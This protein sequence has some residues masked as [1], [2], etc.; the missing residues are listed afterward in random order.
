[1]FQEF[2]P[3][4][5]KILIDAEQVFQAYAHAREL[6]SSYRGSMH[7]KTVNG[8]KYLYRASNTSIPAKSLGPES[9]ETLRIYGEFQAGKAKHAERAAHIGDKLKLQARLCKA[10]KINRVPNVTTAILRQLELLGLLGKNLSVIGTHALFAY[11]AAA[12]GQF[13][14]EIT[15]TTDV[16]FMWDV[17]AR[18]VMA[19]DMPEYQQKGF[20][21]ILKKVDP[22]FEPMKNRGFRAVNKEGFLVDLVK[23]APAFW[24]VEPDTLGPED[25]IWASEIPS[26]KWLVSSPKLSQ[27]IIGEDGYPA[28]MT[29]PDPRAFAL[30]KLWLSHQPDREPVKKARDR[31]QAIAVAKVVNQRL[32]QWPFTQHHLKAFPIALIEQAE[33]PMDD[34]PSGFFMGH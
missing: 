31:L 1:M 28:M 6:N 15:T 7:W 19:V 17:R 29:V 18:L 26:L 33:Q 20:L 9:D 25:G 5:A 2:T 34:L 14:S 24:K 22:S 12:A 11:E 21:G 27:I 23:P 16:D 3:E 13:S 10:I 32:P 30:H 8:R 4:Q